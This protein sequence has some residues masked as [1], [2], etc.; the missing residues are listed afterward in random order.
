MKDKGNLSI[1]R[2]LTISAREQA[3]ITKIVSLLW[4]PALRI[5]KDENLY[6]LD[7][8][9]SIYSWRFILII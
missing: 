1:G 5:T 9:F 2:Y 7:F 8:N 6:I 4:F 3:A